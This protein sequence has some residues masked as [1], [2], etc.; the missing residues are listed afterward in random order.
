MPTMCCAAE[1]HAQNCAGG[2]S[3]A[4]PAN[5]VHG[6]RRSA[7]ALMQRAPAAGMRACTAAAGA[8]AAEE[9]L[10]AVQHAP[11]PVQEPGTPEVPAGRPRMRGALDVEAAVVAAAPRWLGLPSLPAPTRVPAGVLASCAV[12]ANATRVHPLAMCGT[13]YT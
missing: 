1:A 9:R 13:S 4:A 5:A 3:R 7:C 11:P 6:F 8:W 12:H 2:D 10:P